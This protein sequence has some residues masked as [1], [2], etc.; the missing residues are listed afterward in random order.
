MTRPTTAWLFVIALTWTFVAPPAEAHW[1]QWRGLRNSGVSDDANVPAKWSE[2]SNIAWTFELPGP[3]GSTPVVW[4]S[5]IF[6]TSVNGPGVS[7]VC[8]DTSGKMVWKRPI[9][10]RNKTA[11]GDEGTSASPSPSTD[12]KHVWVMANG[13]LRCFTLAGDE[14]WHVDL[15]E[16]YGR[17]R[18][19]FGM[20]STP[21]LDGDRLYLQLIH[22]GGAWVVALEK[23]TGKEVWKVERQSDGR[24]ECEHS[25]A[26]PIMYYGK[27]NQKYLVTHGND[28]AI[29][30]DLKD[31]SEIWRLADL[32]PKGS[33][34]PTLRFVASPA[35]APGLI[36]VPSAKRR[37][38]VGVK[39]DATG[40]INKGDSG[41]QWRLDRMTPDV[42]SP[43][44]HNG[45]VYICS[46]G[47]Q[48]T[49]VDAKTG[50]QY[51]SERMHRNRY[52]GSPLYAD[53]KIYCTA[54]DGVVTVVQAGKSFK[55][56]AE[57]KVDDQTAA[58]PAVS[59]GRIY[60]R[61]F[62]K[63]YAIGK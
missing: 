44:I 7:V 58:S 37:D 23:T 27:G 29:A 36:V 25:Y 8:I 15:E 45:L 33:Y 5:Y 49:C 62:K 14:V 52:R 60:L 55:K 34:N 43:L 47:G 42:P 57:N 54:R 22:S 39:P 59:G 1:P 48:L 38:I 2:S 31:G 53:G 63:L 13:D 21:V 50:E 32:N 17:F 40:R 35:T 56:L 46:E 18:I 61:G 4:G 24:A 11:R 51:Y 16:R 20:T 10:D 9:S 3:G 19:A 41:E 6:V 12:G 30:H 26:S 28:Y